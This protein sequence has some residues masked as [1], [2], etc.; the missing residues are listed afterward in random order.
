MLFDVERSY[1]L[2]LRML[3]LR[4]LSI[5]YAADVALL[6]LIC[7]WPW[8]GLFGRE[9]WKAD[10]GYTFGVIWSMAQGKGWLVPLLAGEPFVEKPPLFYWVAALCTQWFGGAL[11]PHE[12]ARIAVAFF[13]YVTLGFLAA[14]ANALFGARRALVTVVLFIGS[15]GL[16]DKVHILIADVSL[17]SGLSIGLFGLATSER[18]PIAGGIAL[19]IG[20][21]VAFMSKGAIGLGI[22]AVT[23]VVLLY[24]P[25]WRTAHR[26]KSLAVAAVVAAPAVIAWPAALNL[27]SP[28]LF[29]AWLWINNLGRF[30]GFARLGES[31]GLWF[32]P[33]TLFWL[34]FP[35]WPFAIAACRAA[36]IRKEGHE[37][38]LLP[39]IAFLVT[40]GILM[41]AWQ[42]RAIYALPALLPLSLLAAAGL[43]HAP[44]WFVEG[45]QRWSMWLFP[46]VAGLLWLAWLAVG[47]DLPWAVDKVT[48][49]EPGFL[50]PIE[51]STVAIALAGSALWWLAS[52]RRRISAENSVCVWVAGLTTFWLILLTLWVPYLDYGNSYVTT[53]ASM[54]PVL[55]RDASCV[56]SKGLGES[57]RAM[58]EYYAGL[59]TRRVESDPGA[60]TCKWLLVQR[61]AGKPRPL[62]T[63]TNWRGVW[64]GARPGDD[65]ESFDLYR[66]TAG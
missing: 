23:A 14:T 39:L 20:T 55:P 35:V 57:Q 41:F 29:N 37:A 17:M 61:Q 24:F 65:R 12:A 52:R 59:T 44:R 22:L 31:H 53:A 21:G 51:P 60:R 38:L 16:F 8:I 66:A 62:P 11:A 25:G 3:A 48:Q 2:R 56:A 19:G 47:L 18:R 64:H 15:L 32:Y 28:E 58:F 9:P 36:W 30:F 4:G 5:R 6:L 42:S 46:V 26:R 50:L 13:L 10:E 43:S 33:L 49:R 63:E 45:L 34:S 40:I 7:A 27:T 54:Q 1:W